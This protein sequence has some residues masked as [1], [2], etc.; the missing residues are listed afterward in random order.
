MTSGGAENTTDFGANNSAG[1]V[2]ERIDEP[3]PVEIPFDVGPGGHVLIQYMDLREWNPTFHAPN[4]A[5]GYYGLGDSDPAVANA[6]QYAYDYVVYE[7]TAAT[8]GGSIP[9]RAP[10]FFNLHGWDGNTYGPV[11]QHPDPWWCAYAIYP[12]DVTETWYFGFAAKHDYRK[13]GTLGAGDTIAN[14]TEERL[15]RMVYDLMRHPSLGSRV[16]RDRVYVYGHSMGGSG[17]LALALRYHNVFAA[18]YASQP[19][20]NYRTSGDGGGTDWRGDVSPKWGSPALNLPVRIAGPLDWAG[21]LTGH[22]GTGVWDWQNHQANLQSRVAEEMVPF[23]VGHGTS[24]T[25]IEWTTQ[26]RPAYG[27]FN[28]GR[29][30]WGGAVTADEHSWLSFQGLPPTLADDGTGPFGGFLFVRDE[31]VP[32]LSNASGELTIPPNATGGYNQTLEWSAGWNEWDSAPVDTAG[33]W[34][35]SLRTT[36]GSSQTVDVT[37]RRLQT[38]RTIPGAGYDWENRRVGDDSLVASGSVIADAHALV[39]VLGFQVTASGNRLVLRPLGE[40]PPPTRTLTPTPTVTCACPAAVYVPLVRRDRAISTP[41]PTATATASP[42]ST[43]AAA[44]TATATPSPTATAT[45]TRRPTAGYEGYITFN[46]GLVLS[47]VIDQVLVGGGSSIWVVDADSPQ[48]TLGRVTPNE[49]GSSLMPSWAP[50]YQRIVF[51]SNR[52]ADFGSDPTPLLDI[53]TISPDGSDPRRLTQG[54]GHNW[55]PAWSPDGSMI[56]FASTRNAAAEP[57]DVWRFD[58]F[59]MDANGANQR[60]LADTGAQDEDPVFSADSRTVYFVA[61]QEACYQIWQVPAAGGSTSPLRDNTGGTVCGEDVGLSPDGRALFFFSSNGQLMRI[62]LTTSQV[63][64][65][66]YDAIEPWI[67]PDGTRLTFVSSDFD[68]ASGGD[69]MVSRLDGSGPMHITSTGD[70]FFPR[71]AAPTR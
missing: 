3:L 2:A 47:Q 31:S 66:S 52:G 30:A 37:P 6:I 60:L 54:S 64:G 48:A 18:A 15:L 67:G 16:D 11:T 14:Y 1:P 58:I 49:Q 45:P 57:D 10:V 33:Q 22:D 55:T 23:G 46:R 71:W 29:R 24:D 59:V 26:G 39:T 68:L 9:D 50:D 44:R 25:V 70:T 61:E 32:G 63:T 38:F 12:V 34:R 7:P 4:E 62:D 21:H 19:M 5:N 69:V 51:S 42:S 35:I 65:Y 41:V 43:V 28:A 53:W 27:A 40:P 17:T 56:A 36:D 8:C 20:T 13:G